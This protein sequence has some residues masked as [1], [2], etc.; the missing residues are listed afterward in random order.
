MDTYG[1][2]YAKSIW[3]P[4]EGW[5]DFKGKDDKSKY[6]WVFEVLTPSVRENILKSQ[7]DPNKTGLTL[8]NRKK[9]YYELGLAAN[10]V[11]N[12]CYLRYTVPLNEELLKGDKRIDVLDKILSEGRAYKKE[13]LDKHENEIMGKYDIT[14][15][16]LE[17]IRV[18][19][20]KACWPYAGEELELPEKHETSVD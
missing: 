6:K 2:A 3:S 14:K 18:E 5:S 10:K 11:F 13:S 8:E 7:N 1:I 20:G 17:N 19:G 15:I 12:E 16:N 4:P 9:I